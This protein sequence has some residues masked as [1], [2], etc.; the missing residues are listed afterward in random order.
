[1]SLSAAHN[2]TADAIAAGKVAQAIALKHAAKLP[3]D[4][5][6]LHDAQKVWSLKQDDSYETFRRKS[7]P[8]FEVVR[9]WP[10]KL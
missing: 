7:S 6:E 8:D 4:A 2:A 5:L 10:V 9:G 1:V 3:A